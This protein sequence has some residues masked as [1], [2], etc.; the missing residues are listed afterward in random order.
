MNKYI[1]NNETA[2]TI[3]YIKEIIVIM[4]SRND[5]IMIDDFM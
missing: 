5:H 2:E 4:W 3:N 1:Y